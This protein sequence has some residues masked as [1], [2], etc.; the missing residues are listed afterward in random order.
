[1]W[2][3]SVED[4]QQIAVEGVVEPP[5]E[6][7]MLPRTFPVLSMLYRT[8]CPSGYNLGPIIQEIDYDLLILRL[9]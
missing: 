6:F 3:S 8:A 1:M 2:A 9:C 4:D 5:G 7:S